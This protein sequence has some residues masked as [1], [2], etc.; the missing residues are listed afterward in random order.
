MLSSKLKIW[1]LGIR[2]KTLAASISPVIMGLA[3]A[4]NDRQNT[5][6]LPAAILTFFAAL[7][8]QAGTNLS[9]DLFD[10]IKGADNK[11][12]VGPLRIMQSGLVA[13]KEM[14]LGILI[15]F[16]LASACG[17]FLVIRGGLPILIIGIIS[18]ICGFLYT[19]GPRPLGYIGLGELFVLF[20]F[21]IIAFAGTY[22]I[23]TLVFSP[24]LVVL[25]LI[26]G[27]F[28][29][30]ILSANNLRDIKTDREAGKKT[31]AVRFGY[32]FAISEYV[33]CMLIPYILLIIMVL[34]LQNH[35]Y[36]LLSL[37]SIFFAVMPI[38]IVLNKNNHKPANLIYVL[39]RTGQV[40]L[41]FS[42]IFCITW[43][44]NI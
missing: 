9:N 7:L 5:L 11:K 38:R 10:Y 29:V 35:Y 43:N 31:L 6:H 33:F 14:L 24:I 2:P 26:P 17:V 4:F 44:I 12:R 41:I 36:S 32:K 25:G 1:I 21:G 28:S 39:E 15:V 40:M 18:I 27:F 42:L 13:K 19:A 34:T 22:Y 30:A 37:V 20:F 16:F 8:I 23:Q 3:V